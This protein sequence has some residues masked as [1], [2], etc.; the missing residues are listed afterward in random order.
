MLAYIGEFLFGAK[1]R[2]H[3]WPKFRAEFLKKH[4]TCAACGTTSKLDVHHIQP[5]H[6]YP[7]LE[8]SEENCIV[9]CRTGGSCHITFGHLQDW[10]SWN[11]HVREDAAQYLHRVQTRPFM[12]K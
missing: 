4:P 10:T 5:F 2:D 7:H 12:K 11:I 3:R 9:L 6:V 1:A 8:L